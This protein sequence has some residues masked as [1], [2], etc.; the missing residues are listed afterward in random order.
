[1]I[2]MSIFGA[3]TDRTNA[4]VAMILPVMHT[5]RQPNLFVRALTIGPAR[6]RSHYANMSMQYTAI[7]HGCKN[8]I[9]R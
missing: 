6:E 1:M 5:G 8:G 4:R 7:F 9:L 3:N 2:R